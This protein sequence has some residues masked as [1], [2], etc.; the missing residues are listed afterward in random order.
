MITK[1]L[2]ALALGLSALTAHGGDPKR[3][4]KEKPRHEIAHPE[5]SSAQ[6]IIERQELGLVR[7]TPVRSFYA[8]GQRVDYYIDGSAYIG[9]NRVR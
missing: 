4:E 9:L 6:D 7:G 3:E 2:I 8:H 5:R 1:T